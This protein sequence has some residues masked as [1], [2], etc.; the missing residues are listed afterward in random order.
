MADL[1]FS[2][3]AWTEYVEW[4]ATDKATAKRINNLLKEIMRTPFEGT[5]QP[6]AL[7]HELA[8]KWSRRINQKDRLVYEV[9]ADAIRITQCKGHY[10]DK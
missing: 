9:T 10:D 1:I 5:G 3:I 6:E 4:L 8:G 7:K 2:E